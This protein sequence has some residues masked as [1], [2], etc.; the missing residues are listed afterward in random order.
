MAGQLKIMKELLS[1]CG[2]L[3][4]IEDHTPVSFSEFTNSV[5]SQDV[6]KFL[7]R[8]SGGVQ[9]AG[10]TATMQHLYAVY[11][12]SMSG[13]PSFKV[14]PSLVSALRDTEIPD[15]KIEFFRSPFVGFS[16]EIPKGT[17]AAPYDYVSRLHVSHVISDG[18]FRVVFED[19]ADRVTFVSILVS[20][21]ESTIVE[22][23]DAT[24]K[25]QGRSIPASLNEELMEGIKVDDLFSIDILQFAVNTVLYITSPDADCYVD[26]SLV[27][28][29]HT[30]LQ[31]VR[32]GRK[33]DV[34][35]G[36]LREAK[37]SPNYVVGASFRLS[38]EYTAPLTEAGKKWSLSHRVRVMGHFRNQP[39]GPKHKDRNR[40]WVAPHWKGPAFAEMIEKGYVVK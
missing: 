7:T 1:L 8:H 25:Q 11:A 23:I 19:A 31:G 27:H 9:D 35:L 24:R 32:G 2:A 30:Q 14:S 5:L 33:R 15:E 38:E 12:W 13:F 40:I 28:E 29:L 16:V 20:N 37:A 6:L 26:K 34:L 22:A 3:G 18:K 17:F 21:P 39:C 36:K 4:P 10:A